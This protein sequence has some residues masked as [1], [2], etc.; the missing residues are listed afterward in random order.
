[1]RCQALEIRRTI[2]D[3]HSSGFHSGGGSALGG[4]RVRRK[5]KERVPLCARQGFPRRL[6]STGLNG[7]RKKKTGSAETDPLVGGVPT[8]KRRREQ[9][10]SQVAMEGSQFPSKCAWGKQGQMRRKRGA[11]HRLKWKKRTETIRGRPFLLLFTTSSLGYEQTPLEREKK[12]RRLL[13]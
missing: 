5:H 1:L 7:L 8:K 4:K 2:D 12:G 13:S 9:G 3:G 11:V 6:R 10:K